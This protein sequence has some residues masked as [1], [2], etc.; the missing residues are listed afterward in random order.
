MVG[1]LVNAPAPRPEATCA[2]RS[3]RPDRQQ[4][5]SPADW[6][7]LTGTGATG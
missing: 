6:H 4:R 3:S 5:I 1:F 2:G 7:R